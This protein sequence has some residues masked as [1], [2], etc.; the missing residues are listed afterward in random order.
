MI[1]RNAVLADRKT[2]KKILSDHQLP[3]EDCELHLEHFIVIEEDN[4]LIGLG[5][6]EPYG[7]NGLLR[8]IVVIS[9][10]RN[11]GVGNTIYQ[12]L[13]TYARQ[14]GIRTLYLLTETATDYFSALGFKYISRS[15]TPI[16]IKNTQ[17]FKNLCPEHATVMYRNI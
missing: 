6:I 12:L 8:S 11:N 3:W 15:N 17:Q 5:G 14:L 10:Y 2:I 16:S 1:T 4:N 13:Q 7:D 9:A